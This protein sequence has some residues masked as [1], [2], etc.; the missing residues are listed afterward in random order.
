MFTL[1]NASHNITSSEA[2]DRPP[3]KAIFRVWPYILLTYFSPHETLPETEKN[4]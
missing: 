3:E 2:E 1:Y 4:V